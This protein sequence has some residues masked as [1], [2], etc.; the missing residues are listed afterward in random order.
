MV[1]A[2]E[3]EGRLRFRRVG[4]ID[5]RILPGQAFRIG[6]RAVPGVIGALPPHLVPR[7]DRD[8]VCE[9]SSCSNRPGGL[10]AAALN[11]VRPAHT[12]QGVRRSAKLLA[13]DFFPRSASG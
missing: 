11:K 9:D 12:Q 7:A 6:P 4:G 8:K 2:V 13:L 1:T 10:F 3:K 5:P